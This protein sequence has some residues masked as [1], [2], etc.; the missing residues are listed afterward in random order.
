MRLRFDPSLPHQ[1]EAIQAVTD[2]F[3]GLPMADAPLS[4]STTANALQFTEYGVGNTVA[5]DADALLAN[6][7]KVQERNQIPTTPSMGEPR[8]AVEMETGTGKTYV[9]LRTIFELHKLYGLK[10]FVIV[11]PSIPIREGVLHSISTMRDHF[12]GLYNVT[13]EHFVYDSSRLTQIRSFAMANTIQIMVINIQAFIRD[14]DAKDTGRGAGNVIYREF[15]KLNGL[16]PI[17]YLQ[18]TNPVVIVD[19]PQ[20]VQAAKSQQAIR[21][22]NPLVTL[23]YSAT[24]ESPQKVYKLGPIEA[25]EQKLVK[26]IEVASVVAEDDAN[27]AYVKFIKADI[28]KQRTQIEITGGGV[29]DPTRQKIWIKQGDDLEQKSNGRPEYRQGFRVTSLGWEPGN[30]FIEFSGGHRVTPDAALGEM[31]DAIMKAQIE[32]TIRQHFERELSLR[33]HGIKVLSLFFIDRVANYREYDEQ[34]HPQP[35]KIARWFEE[36]YADLRQRY[37]DRYGAIDHPPVERLHDGYFSVDN[38]KRAKDTSGKTQGDEDTYELIMRDKERLLSLSEPLRFIFSHS[39]LREGWDNPNVFQICTLNETRSVEKKRQEIGRGLRLPVNQLGERIHD[40]NVNRLT[41]V[42]NESYREFAETLQREY[43]QEAGIRFGEVPRTAFNNVTLPTPVGEDLVASS[44]PQPIGEAASGRIFSHLV[45]HGYLNWAGEIQDKYA[46]N[47]LGFTLSVPEEFSDEDTVAQINDVIKRYVFRDRIVRP[48]RQKQRIRVNDRVLDNEEFLT[49]WNHVA[50]RTRYIVEFDTEEL[51]Q[52]A[53]MT[54]R[55]NVRLAPPRITVQ[56]SVLEQTRAGIREGAALYRD[57][58]EATVPLVVPDVLTM[59][60][61]ETNLT[62]STISKI[63]IASG[64]AE[65]IR[66]NPQSFITQATAI[67]KRELQR[68]MQGGLKYE[69]REGDVWQV[70]LFRSQPASAYERDTDRLYKVENPDR[71]VFD[72]VELD[73]GIEA[74]FVRSLDSDERIRYHV[75]LPSW[76]TVDTPVG[77]YNPDWAIMMQDGKSFYLVRETKGTLVAADRRGRE[78]DKIEAARKHFAAIGVDYNVAT[79]FSDVLSQHHWQKS[80]Q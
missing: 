48:A 42:A 20:R 2:L 30:E 74:Q 75:K 8:F 33:D 40:P 24:F 5:L 56:R 73:S 51:I 44:S 16:K 78:N 57:Q 19:E 55:H 26:Q 35:G 65:D 31:T 10:K 37:P 72:Y 70:R 50:Q 45:H 69:K 32:T 66:I 21:N 46:P 60:Q 52:Q 12:R 77:T 1:Q 54:I 53:A 67:I 15:D 62:R 71:T 49:F 58:I 25:Y 22:L 6:L 76:F 38:Q 39:A 41:V 7:Q 18:Q 28:A 34:S 27:T 79:S 11:V 43:E 68:M 13:F 59:I 80:S 14:L 9:Y 64:K 3:E 61:G 29:A 17:E 36:I 4:I 47:Q 23:E 63:L